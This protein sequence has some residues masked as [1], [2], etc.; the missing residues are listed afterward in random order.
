MFVSASRFEREIATLKSGFSAMLWAMEC[1]LRQSNETISRQVHALRQEL[2][3]EFGAASRLAASLLGP[4]LLRTIRR[5]EKRLADGV[6][7]EPEMVVER[8]DWS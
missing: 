7:Y 1:H 4:L 6:A 5:E 8:R 3:A 2:A